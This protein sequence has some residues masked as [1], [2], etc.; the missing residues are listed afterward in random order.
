MSFLFLLPVDCVAVES[1]PSAPLCDILAGEEE[2]IQGA[3][4]RRR[5]EF[6]R[7]RMCARRA[8]RLLGRGSP[9]HEF[10]SDANGAPPWP[11]GTVGSMTHSMGRCAVVVGRSEAWRGIGIDIEPTRPIPLGIEALLCSDEEVVLLRGHDLLHPDGRPLVRL[12]FSLKEAGVKCLY[13]AGVGRFSIVDISVSALDSVQGE[14]TL[15]VI[16]GIC[17]QGRFRIDL[18]WIRCVVVMPGPR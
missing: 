5:E 16:S 7:V 10:L 4:P 17:L 11:K 18:N 13:S 15:S 14:A 9:W 1:D 6:L 12:I 2:W 3:D 8:L